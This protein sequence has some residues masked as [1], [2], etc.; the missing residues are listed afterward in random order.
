MS[1]TLFNSIGWAVEKQTIAAGGGLT[2]PV[3]VSAVSTDPN[4]VRLTFDRRLMLEYRM[5]GIYRALTLDLLSFRIIKVADSSTLEIV[6]TIWVNET[7][8]D[9]ATANQQAF[10]YQVTCVAGGVM[11]FWGNTISEQSTTFTGQQ[12]VDYTTPGSL[13]VF[14]SGYP[15]MQEDESGEFY[16]DLAAPYLTNRDPA[17]SATNVSRYTNILLDLLDDGLG[18]KLSTVRIWVGGT[19]A[20]RGDTDTF[21][22]PF[23]GPSSSRTAIPLGHRFV[24][25]ATFTYASYALIQVDV[26]AD[27]LA[28]IPNSLSTSYSFR[29]VDDA[30]P[31]LANRTPG[32]GATD[33]ARN[34][35][36]ALDILDD[37]SGVVESSVWIKVNGA[38]A[39]LSSASQPGFVVTETP[40]PNGYR[41][42][43]DPNVDFGSYQTV[44]IDV[45]AQDSGSPANTL[46][47]TYS[48]RTA[49][50]EAP[51]ISY[52]HPTQGDT[53]VSVWH[54]V[55]IDIVDDGSGVN[56]ASMVIIIDGDVAWTG[57]TAQPGFTGSTKTTISGGFRYYIVH[58]LPF[59]VDYDVVVSVLCQDM[60]GNVYNSS[61]SFHTET[62]ATPVIYDVYPVA[63]QVNV[64]ASTTLR[65]KITDAVLDLNPN[66]VQCV[67][68][69]VV[70]YENV[71]EK[72]G[73]TVV[74]TTIPGGFSY[75]VTP[76][77]EFPYT[78]TVSVFIYAEDYSAASTSLSFTFDVELS[79]DCFTGPL[80]AFEETIIQPFP[81]TLKNLE[82]IRYSLIQNFVKLNPIVGTRAVFLVG[83]AHELS[84][85]L[86][87]LVPIPTEEERQ[88]L[89][90]KRRNLL[91]VA[92]LI[93]EKRI[94]LRG[95]LTE[96]SSLGVPFE[97]IQ[98][99]SSYVDPADDAQTIALMC[100]VVLLAK[101][102]V[103]S[104]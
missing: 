54:E 90:C 73:Y 11:D 12:K 69:E 83:H 36:I 92:D 29:T 16:P 88:T 62:G 43:I 95:S 80:N 46:N 2:G 33:V 50:T 34:T 27:D 77:I 5:W 15:G 35:N 63:D 28:V 86:R 24:I 20:Y 96:L 26:N 3:L 67:I 19:L 31:Y 9:L 70:A 78:S 72:N 103:P 75:V 66:S 93:P 68:N 17:P 65:F 97:H 13:H 89:L 37:E 104:S 25:D 32:I 7:T 21:L 100:F 30:A 41:Y 51:Y 55:N 98:L 61:Y 85:I 42:L 91:T 53:G 40:L 59:T 79:P 81:V 14:T 38:Y 23:N 87:D 71:T 99:I 49:D 60:K 56:A 64:P 84:V 57:D 1:L 8:I 47:T 6:R 74:R 58:D 76:P 101:S 48:F 4:T 52:R 22:A 10:T 45:Y 44:P 102:F 39:W 94:W 82:A 18:V